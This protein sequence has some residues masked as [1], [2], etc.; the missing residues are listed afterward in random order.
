M[1][2]AQVFGIVVVLMLRL[3]PTSAGVI[4]VNT[5]SGDPPTYCVATGGQSK[6]SCW[7]KDGVVTKDVDPAV[8]APLLGVK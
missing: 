7:D 1:S 8:I 5:P 4:F 2:T 6:V 3:L